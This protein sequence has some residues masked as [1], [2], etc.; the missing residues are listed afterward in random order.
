MPAAATS[1][2]GD[3]RDLSLFYGGGTNRART[4]ALYA[5]SEVGLRTGTI[6]GLRFRRSSFQSGPAR[7]TIVVATIEMSVSQASTMAPSTDFAANHGPNRTVVFQG[8]INLPAYPASALYPAPFEAPIVFQTPFAYDGNAGQ[9]LVIDVSVAGNSRVNS[10][11]ASCATVAYGMVDTEYVSSQ[12]TTIDGRISGSFG[13]NQFQP[14]TGSSFSLSHLG[15]AEKPSYQFSWMLIGFAATG[16]AF[17]GGTLPMPLTAL[18]FAANPN[19]NLVVQPDLVEPMQYFAGQN[20]SPGVLAF[21]P[22]AVPADPSWVGL[23]FYTQ[24]MSLDFDNT[25]MVEPLVFPSLALRWTIGSGA[26]PTASKI[27]K[28]ND[29]NPPAT[30][31]TPTIGEAPVF[32]LDLR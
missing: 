11:H 30:T 8:V 28:F 20:G 10:W 3:Y 22:I 24:S 12:C 7:D 9:S 27:V 6:H 25:N 17:G 16:S 18:G 2:S 21:G 29:T 15:F 13:F 4:Q 19:C 1:Q 31:G 26:M 5:T 14:M 32:E 23:R